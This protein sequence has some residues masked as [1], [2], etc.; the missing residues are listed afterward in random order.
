MNE[1]DVKISHLIPRLLHPNHH[2]VW[3]AIKCN[4]NAF[5]KMLVLMLFD[6]GDDQAIMQAPT[7]SCITLFFN[8]G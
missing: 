6:H 8:I 2:F 4:T 1:S 3:Q 5:I 7:P